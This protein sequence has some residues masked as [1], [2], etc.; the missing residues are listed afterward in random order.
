MW[1]DPIDVTENSG[2]YMSIT[3]GW[4]FFILIF[5]NAFPYRDYEVRIQVLNA[6]NM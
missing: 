1:L 4:V 2:W 5:Y 3:D 6:M